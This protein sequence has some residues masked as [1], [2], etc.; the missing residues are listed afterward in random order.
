MAL[1]DLLDLEASRKVKEDITK[2]R[3]LGCLQQ[4]KKQI[5]FYRAYPDLFVDEL[6]GYADWCR[7]SDPLKEEWKGFKFFYFQRISNVVPLLHSR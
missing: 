4:L 7:N 1:Q 5:A 3:L 6:S 2:D